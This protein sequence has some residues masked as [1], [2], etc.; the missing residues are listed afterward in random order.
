MSA[1]D[2]SD[3]VELEIGRQTAWARFKDMVR[4]QPLGAAGALIVVTMIVL[5]VFADTITA[6]DPT[7]NKFPDMLLS[8]GGEYWLGTDQFGRDILDT[9]SQYACRDSGCEGCG[10][11]KPGYTERYVGRWLYLYW[12]STTTNSHLN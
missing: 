10:G 5:A 12:V 2:I 8:P 6:F 4:K 9:D 7:D 1:A 3:G 11:N